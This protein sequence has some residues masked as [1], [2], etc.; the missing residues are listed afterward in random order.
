MATSRILAA[1][2]LAA[3]L[4]P[5]GAMSAS[6]VPE[7]RG[8]TPQ[9]WAPDPPVLPGYFGSPSI[10]S[11][12]ITYFPPTI[13]PVLPTCANI[14][15]PYGFTLLREQGF[16]APLT[17]TATGVHATR[18]PALLS[19]IAANRS[20]SCTWTNKLTGRV[21]TTTVTQVSV[22][23]RDL[24]DATLLAAGYPHSE[25]AGDFY[26]YQRTVWPRFSESHLMQLDGNQVGEDFWVATRDTANGW[27][28][29][30]T[31]SADSQVYDL[32][33]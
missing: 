12:P 27:A 10:P 14:Q 20:V 7:S 8:Y 21:L 28:G 5:A 18:I 17:T 13:G 24:V 25:P 29:A 23:E 3:L 1:A 32:N 4:I 31:Q 2:V 30:F 19:V 9:P 16:G 26:N 6:A 33:H 15:T 22:A 11:F